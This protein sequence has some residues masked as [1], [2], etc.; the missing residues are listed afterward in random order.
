MAEGKRVTAAD[1]ELGEILDSAAPVTLKE[2]RESLEREMVQDA[3]E[4]GIQSPHTLR[5][6]GETRDPE[7]V[8]VPTAALGVKSAD[9]AVSRLA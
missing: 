9:V 6:G 5:P 7:G 1:L 2:A 3:L 4:L 8:T